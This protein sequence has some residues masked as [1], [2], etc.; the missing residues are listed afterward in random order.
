MFSYW[1]YMPGT[2]SSYLVLRTWY[3]VPGIDY[4]ILREVDYSS[5]SSSAETAPAVYGFAE[6]SSAA[7]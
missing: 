7:K 1:Y 3:Y 4:G 2:S 6:I 5:H